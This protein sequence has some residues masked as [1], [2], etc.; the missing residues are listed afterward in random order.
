MALPKDNP[1]SFCKAFI[2][3]ELD[4]FKEDGP[5]WMTVVV[6]RL[7]NYTSPIAAWSPK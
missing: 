1:T 2:Q 6:K 7:A 5:I 4:S 3:R